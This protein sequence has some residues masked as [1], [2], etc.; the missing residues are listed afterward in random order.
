VNTPAK[1]I[2]RAEHL[3]KSFRS[4]CVVEDLSLQVESG[5][6]VGLLGPN[7]A[8]KTTDVLHD[9]RVDPAGRGQIRLD[10]DDITGCRCTSA[11]G[12]AS[13]TCRRKPRVPE[14]VGRGQHPRDPRD[15]ADLDRR[16]GRPARGHPRG[17]SH[18]HVRASQGHALSGGERRRVEIARALVAEPRFMLLDEPFAGVDPISVHDIQQIVASLKDRGI[19]VLITDHN[20]ERNTGRL[21]PRL[22][23]WTAA[24]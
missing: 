15:A 8:G 18:R 14:A 7:G 19:G 16:S 17:A 2:L 21:Q 5:E 24:R 4:R 10:G 22:H 20:V 11:R 12:A 1:S 13:A 23:H 3:R 9:R 6:I